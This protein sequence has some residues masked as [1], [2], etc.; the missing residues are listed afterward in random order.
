MNQKAMWQDKLK[1]FRTSPSKRVWEKI[2]KEL[3]DSDVGHQN[4]RRTIWGIAAPIAIALIAY[5]IGVKSGDAPDYF[6]TT[7]EIRDQASEVMIP[8]EYRMPEHNLDH[9]RKDGYLIPNPH[10]LWD[11]PLKAN[12]HL[13]D[14][15]L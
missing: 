4:Q 7:L 3:D 11:N 1:D 2:E 6:P 8:L 10:A 5:L 9:N 14:R 12:P 13:T 15:G